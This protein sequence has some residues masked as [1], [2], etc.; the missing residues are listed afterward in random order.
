MCVA[1]ATINDPSLAHVERA[2]Q[3]V[4]LAQCFAANVPT[5]QTRGITLARNLL[6]PL[7]LY[8]VKLTYSI[9]HRGFAFPTVDCSEPLYRRP[10]PRQAITF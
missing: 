10:C 7:P 6:F 1:S 9:G 8:R 5:R 3:N 4:L 2:K